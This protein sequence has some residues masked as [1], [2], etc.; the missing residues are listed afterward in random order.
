M[1]GTDE[2]L[3]STDVSGAS[4]RLSALIDQIKARLPGASIV[5]SSLPRVANATI[6]QRIQTYNAAIPGIVS[7]KGSNVTF[8]DAYAAIQA[9]HLHADGVHLTRDGYSRLSDV[10]SPAVHGILDVLAPPTPTP[11][12]TPTLTPTST[13]T[14][15]LTLT[16]TSTL[17]PTT[18]VTPSPCSPRPRV[19]VSITREALGRLR[20][21]ILVTGDGNGLKTLRIG[22]AR[23]A[24]V[25]V[26]SQVAN[27]PLTVSLPSLPTAVQMTVTRIRAGESATVPFAVEDR[28]GEWK[29]LVG[30][31]PGAF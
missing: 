31:G 21:T 5:V 27:G 7:T 16:P 14:P 29:T 30:G 6:H 28:C 19:V 24:T 20:A 1:A 15:T 23:N 22:E 26:G 9:V 2:L 10:W 17:T 13:P 25:Q 3:T 8:V 11:T 4:A 18:T 12:R